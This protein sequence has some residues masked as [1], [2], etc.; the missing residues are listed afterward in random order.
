MSY[1]KIISSFQIYL[2]LI[3]F[4]LGWLSFRRKKV[5][6]SGFASISITTAILILSNSY[7]ILT[8]ISVTFISSA[9]IT[10]FKKKLS[11]GSHDNNGD[12]SPRNW[13]QAIA[14]IGIPVL[15]T[16]VQ[17]P[18]NQKS[19]IFTAFAAL[20][21]S[22][23]DTWSSEIGVL[24]RKKPIF[25]LSRKITNSGVSGG[26]TLLGTFCSIIGSFIISAV[27]LYYFDSIKEASIIL[28]LGFL[29][30]LTDSLIG[31]LFQAKYLSSTNEQ[32]DNMTSGIVVKGFKIITNNI[33][34][35]CP[36]AFTAVM[37]YQIHSLFLLI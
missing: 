33:V 29:G 3:Y 14:N 19:L 31:E 12:E 16:L 9:I 22:T 32:T 26:V 15:L 1:F 10:T 23:A 4:V 25:L 37:A 27:Y 34:N 2:F 6:R 5:D 30:A 18:T 24:S 11:F 7:A 17:Y 13:K 8:G 21:C 20:A 28:I 36:V 35:L